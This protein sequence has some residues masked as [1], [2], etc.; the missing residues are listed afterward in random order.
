M[1]SSPI[2]DDVNLVSFSILSAGNEI[3]STYEVLEITVEQHV[4]RI[5]EAEITL[6]DGNSGTQTFDI[7]DSDTF[8]PGTEIE[9]KMGYQSH[10]DSVYKGIVTKQIIKV[11]DVSGSKLHVICK[12]EAIKMAINRKNGIFTEIKDSAL[13]EQLAGDYSL[14]TDVAATTLQHK[15]IVQYYST[16]WDFTINRAEVNGMVVVTDSGK[17]TVAKPAVSDSPELQVQFGYDIIEFDGELDATF[18]YSGVQGNA[19]DMSSQSVINAT[20]VE[21]SVNEQGDLT[22]STL[23]DVLSA[24]TKNLNASVP[25]VQDDVQAWADAAL[26]KSRLSRFKGSITFQGSAKAKVNSTIKLMGLSARFNGNAFISGVTHTIENGRWLTESIIGL[27]PEWFVEKHPVS[28]P[29]ASGLLPGVKGLQTG[30]VKKIDSDP[31]NEFRVQVEIPILGDDSDAVWARLSTFYAGNSFGAFF[32]PEVNDE[33]ILGFMNDDPRF[34]VIMGSVFSS[35]IPAPETPDEENSI[36]TLITK[37]KLQLEFDD[38][39]KVI[40]VLTPGGNTMVFSDKDKGIT[41]TDQNSNKIETNDKGV[42]ITDTS[43]NK[44]EMVSD[45]ITLDSKKNVTLKATD[46]V[47][48]KGK[49][50]TID[51]S[52]ST[53]VKG[54][55][56]CEV[57]SSS[58]VSVKGSTVMIN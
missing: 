47:S 33:V 39:N 34:P 5:A 31:D 1:P 4:N 29:I 15:E 3:P 8:K 14:S 58:E 35:S 45:G 26:L 27:S 46:D 49:S 37:S 22:G 21:P 6:R 10:N 23:A 36:K 50:I 13:I 53:T 7:T 16:D 2:A 12:D 38:K 42:T 19:W 20:A 52:Q 9:I 32:M 44:I 18:Q 48:I 30:I 41:I 40:T 25:I 51:G 56:S 57:S 54:S 55:S 11:D 28:S 43:G 17:L 24:G